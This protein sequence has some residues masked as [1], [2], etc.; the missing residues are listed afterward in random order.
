MEVS[1]PYEVGDV[2]DQYRLKELIGHGSM[3]DV[4]RALDQDNN[5]VVAIKIIHH[6]LLDQQFILERIIR[7]VDSLSALRH[8]NIIRLYDHSITPKLAYMVMEYV[9][10]GTLEQELD[11]ARKSGQS[12]PLQKVLRWMRAICSAVDHAHEN[13]LIHRDLK[14]ANVLFRKNGE[15]VLTDFGLAFLI[16]SPRI[17]VSNSISGTPA[18][19]SPEQARGE[20]GDARSDV[21]SL[22]V[23]LYEILAGR[24]PFEG[25]AVSVIM[26]QVAENP[27]P[28]Q[29][30][31]PEI[32]L[33]VESV[34]LRAL[35]KT[36]RKR[37]QKAGV[38]L[39]GFRIAVQKSPKA[40]VQEGGQTS[41]PADNSRPVFS[42]P[43]PSGGSAPQRSG[44]RSGG[45]T[46]ST[47]GSGMSSY[48]PPSNKSNRKSQLVGC[49][50]LLLISILIG[51]WTFRYM[52]KD[53]A[54][55]PPPQMALGSSVQ[56]SVP[57]KASISMLSGCPGGLL[58][59]L[60]GVATS[61]Q[62]GIIRD[63]RTCGDEWW[64]EVEISELKDGDWDGTGWIDGDYLT[65]Y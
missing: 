17:S 56:V 2:I 4:F 35:E 18:Y 1:V 30:F 58:K 40:A 52:D 62:R 34:V 65:L 13:G 59:G 22:G 46:M 9:D 61:G 25:T 51:Y 26:A 3:A 60:K 27:P 43:A 20:V 15:P 54:V 10:G 36:P 50:V 38:L 44:S 41:R 49:S 23:I 42:T 48:V 39:E 55:A 6:Y 21:Y 53:P 29:E 64:Y 16:G 12:V 19:L 7:E 5:R 11:R 45:N 32:P 14:P 24:A 33:G 8:P 63:R 37:Y 31:R 47:T 57:D 28:I